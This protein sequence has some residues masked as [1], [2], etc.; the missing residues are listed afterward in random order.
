MKPNKR[1]CIR[2]LRDF[3]QNATGERREWPYDWRWFLF[4]WWKFWRRGKS[5]CPFERSLVVDDVPAKCRMIAEQTV[6]QTRSGWWPWT[7]K[8]VDVA[9][10][11]AG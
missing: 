4:V 5:V 8:S 10:K 1:I 6:S 9:S 11:S 7:R 3:D 2:C